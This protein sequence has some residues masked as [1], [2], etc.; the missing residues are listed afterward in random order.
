MLARD[1]DLPTEVRLKSL[2]R[3]HLVDA[4]YL[5]KAFMYAL[6]TKVPSSLTLAGTC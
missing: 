4:S 1:L 3:P 6:G 5:S 2:G